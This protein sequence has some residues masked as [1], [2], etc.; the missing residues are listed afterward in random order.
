MK[1]RFL[2][3]LMALTVAVSARSQADSLTVEGV[4]INTVDGRVLPMCHVQLLQG[5][6]SMGIALTD[7]DGYF[8]LPPLPAGSYTL[9]V[10]QFGDTMMCYKNL[11]LTRDSWLRSI[12]APPAGDADH[13]PML[14]QHPNMVWLQPVNIRGTRNML[15]KMGLL[16]TSPD[17]QRLWNFNGIWELMDAGPA[18]ADLSWPTLTGRNPYRHSMLLTPPIWVLCNEPWNPVPVAQK[19]S[20]KS[21]DNNEERSQEDNN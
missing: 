9:L 11:R 16:I 5:G 3:A 21:E 1:F 2:V 8:E 12:V 17:D 20:E 7:Y 19:E 6:R 4:V 18:S 10:T 15:Y 14:V 13:V